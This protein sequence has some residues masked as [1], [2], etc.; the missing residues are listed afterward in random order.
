M[1]NK[2]SAIITIIL[3]I[4]IILNRRNEINSLNEGDKPKPSILRFFE[5]RCKKEIDWKYALEHFG[6]PVINNSLL[7][8]GMIFII[9]G[10][11]AFL[12]IIHFRN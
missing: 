8:A 5:R 3:G 12:E 6:R 10:L 7:I 2:I 4:F 1:N 9:I 11:L